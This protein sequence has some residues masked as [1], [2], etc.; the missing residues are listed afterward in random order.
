MI[1]TTNSK[2]FLKE[3]LLPILF[4]V[5]L[6]GLL[7]MLFRFFINSGPLI[8][9]TRIVGYEESN[10]T[11]GRLI[12][13][14]L[15][16]IGFVVFSILASKASVDD[17][18]TKPFWFGFVAGVLLWQS[19]GEILWHFYIGG[20]NFVPLENITSFPIVVVILMIFIYAKKHH[21][22]DFG[23]WCVFVTFMCNWLGHYISIGIYPFFSS[24]VS[25]RVWNVSSSIICGG[26]FFLVS[27]KYL[28]FRTATK[29]G[30]LLASLFTFISL[31]IIFFGIVEG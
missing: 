15:S 21:S 11:L 16:F 17:K 7:I 13:G 23:I 30:R 8:Q 22:F 31:A 9:E 5:L 19:I 6:F 12:Y 27:L 20:I 26:L 24:F 10:P 29:R 28:F 2:Q 25:S 14:I 3:Y 4:E 1:K 18:S